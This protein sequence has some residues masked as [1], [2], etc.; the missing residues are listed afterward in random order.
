MAT[1]R[2][3]RRN[4][5][6][7]QAGDFIFRQGDPGECMF[8]IVSGTVQIL[9]NLA[10]R[11][12]EI[13]LLDTGD[14]FGQI[15]LLQG[16]PRSA[17]AKAVTEVRLLTID[18]QNFEELLEMDVEIPIRMMRQLNRALFM[19]ERRLEK[20]LTR[21]S[22]RERR[23]F[24]SD[25]EELSGNQLAG[26]IA[27]EFVIPG[28]E[29]RWPVWGKVLRLGRA[30]KVTGITPEVDLSTLADKHSVSRYHA[31]L[32]SDTDGFKL[33]EELGV[34][35]G[36]FINGRRLKPG[37]AFPIKSGDHVRLGDIE[38]VF[39]ERSGQE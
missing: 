11:D 30:D 9:K 23:E 39:E 6:S 22:E 8:L 12:H 3:S 7:F 17:S 19:A 5:L 10:G 32:L 28:G 15:S 1:Q 4:L 14:F 29:Q 25:T 2:P 26:P 31:R 36:T 21:L 27:A 33:V 13:N 35:N 20:V 24:E 18:K 37:V 16:E 38:L 34:K